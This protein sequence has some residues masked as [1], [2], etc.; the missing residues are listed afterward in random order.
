[1]YILMVYVGGDKEIVFWT[2]SSTEFG[3]VSDTVIYSSAIEQHNI[4]PLFSLSLPDRGTIYVY[5]NRV[6]Q[7][8]LN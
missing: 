3:A 7:K 6:G 2:L 4:T 5:C 8:R 1:M